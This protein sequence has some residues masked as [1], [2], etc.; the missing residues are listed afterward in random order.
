MKFVQDDMQEK[1]DS[2]KQ[3]QLGGTQEVSEVGMRVQRSGSE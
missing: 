1:W 2:L 3:G